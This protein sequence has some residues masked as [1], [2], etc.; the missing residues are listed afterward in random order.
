MIR[1]IILFKFHP[2][3]S[4]ADI[5]ETIHKIHQI[6]DHPDIAPLI[7]NKSTGTDI[8]PR[9]DRFADTYDLAEI[10][11]FKGQADY[12]TYARHTVHQEIK[13]FTASRAKIVRINYVMEA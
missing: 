6:A 7:A 9:A 1:H 12:E 11:D 4:E 10:F 8:H 5:K 2:E 3:T 13:A